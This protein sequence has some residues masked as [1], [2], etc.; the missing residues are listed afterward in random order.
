[1]HFTTNHDFPAGLDR[2]WATFG[3]PAYPR[4][5]YLA[6][7]ARMIRIDRFDAGDGLIEVELHRVVAVGQG[8]LPAW[9]R[10]MVGREQIIRHRSRWRRASAGTIEVELEISPK[11][12]PVRARGIGTIAEGSAGHSRMSL[13]WQV[14]SAAPLLGRSVEKL[15]AA[16]VREA[17]DQDHAYTSRLLSTPR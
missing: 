6:L 5:K 12:L 3:H 11:G 13:D 8:S 17:I 7:G 14:I 16:Q 1:M 10:A 15:F 2:L 9:A 4:E